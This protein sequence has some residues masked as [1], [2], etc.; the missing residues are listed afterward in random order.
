MEY[1]RFSRWRLSIKKLFFITKKDPETLR[2][3]FTPFQIHRNPIPLSIPLAI[4][5]PSN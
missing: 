2:P 5:K 1:I 3:S 4:I